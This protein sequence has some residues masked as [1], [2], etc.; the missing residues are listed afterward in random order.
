MK[1]REVR[2]EIKKIITN[3]LF[4]FNTKEERESIISELLVATGISFNDSTTP[5]MMIDGYIHL[6]GYNP[7]TKKFIDVTVRPYFL[8][9]V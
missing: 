8:H 6:N 5:E 7:E 1:D 9:E 3:R 2:R 4:E